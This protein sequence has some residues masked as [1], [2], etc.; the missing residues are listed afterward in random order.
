MAKFLLPSRAALLLLTFLAACGPQTTTLPTPT[1]QVQPTLAEATVPPAS[2][3]HTARTPTLTPPPVYPTREPQP[4]EPPVAVV[5]EA[6]V[7]TYQGISFSLD[8]TL[9]YSLTAQTCAANAPVED[10]GPYT[11]DA[12]YTLF[13]DPL[14]Q[15]HG[16]PY[17]KPEIKVVPLTAENREG[18]LG[19]WYMPAVLLPELQKVTNDQQA[20]NWFQHSLLNAR[21]QYLETPTLTGARTLTIQ[22]IDTVLFN[23]NILVYRFDGIT[24]DGRYY[25]GL[26]I[27]V[28][29]PLL[30]TYEGT[31]VGNTNPDAIPTPEIPNNIETQWLVIQA[32]NEEVKRHVE[33]ITDAE[34]TPDLAQL[35]AIVTSFQIAAP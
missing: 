6:G 32:Y 4:C 29:A 5:P 7:I 15:E 26:R 28:D 16:N 19:F 23:N 8:P 9:G 24:R 30:L 18:F 3:T 21:A 31:N 14:Y 17:P 11:F 1:L 12:A 25:V 10:G 22:A 33:Q 34:L 35:D 13:T 2:P 27:P 20:A